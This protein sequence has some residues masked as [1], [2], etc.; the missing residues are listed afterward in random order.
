MS[1]EV[2][3][4]RR[5]CRP[6]RGFLFGKSSL[7][8]GRDHLLAVQSRYFSEDYKRFYFKDIQCLVTCKTGTGKTQNMVLGLFGLL[9]IALGIRVQ[10]VWVWPTICWI[11]TCVMLLLLVINWLRSPT[12]DCYLKTAVQ[13]EKLPSLC[14]MRTVKKALGLLEPLIQDVQGSL[15]EEEME[16][17][18]TEGKSQEIDSKGSER[19]NHPMIWESGRTHRTLFYLLLMSGLITALDM[20]FSHVTITLLGTFISLGSGICTIMALVRQYESKT[21]RALRVIT[22]TTLA[23]VCLEFCFSYVFF[24]VAAMKNQEVAHNQWEMIKRLAALSPLDSPWLTGL[25]AFSISL[26]VLLGAAGLILLRRYQYAYKPS[27]QPIP[28]TPGHNPRPLEV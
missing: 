1:K 5:L 12:C 2:K 27:S 25:F 20:R 19:S 10:G 21:P 16:T 14:R 8:L 24:F 17:N 15:T 28:V 11:A 3:T 6:K 18:L 13:T 23:F 9:F 4:Y 26:S 7:W 22:W